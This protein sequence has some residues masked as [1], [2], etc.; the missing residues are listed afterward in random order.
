MG[1]VNLHNKFQVFQI[2]KLEGLPQENYD[3]E[4]NTTFEYSTAKLWNSLPSPIS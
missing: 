3:Q 2:D 1:R 4:Q